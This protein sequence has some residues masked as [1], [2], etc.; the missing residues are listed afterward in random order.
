MCRA[1]HSL[2]NVS[3]HESRLWLATFSL[4][5]R[6]QQR[7]TAGQHSQSVDEFNLEHDDD[8]AA[9]DDDDDDDGDGGGG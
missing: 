9:D 2:L 8:D 5:A 4:I 1:V 6:R 3:F 7:K